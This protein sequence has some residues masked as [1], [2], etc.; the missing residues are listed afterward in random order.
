[1]VDDYRDNDASLLALTRMCIVKSGI[2]LHSAISFCE[3][4]HYLDENAYDIVLMRADMKTGGSTHYENK[5]RD[6]TIPY[7]Q[8]V[9]RLVEKTDAHFIPYTT[10]AEFSDKSMEIWNSMRKNDVRFHGKEMAE[11]LGHPGQERPAAVARALVKIL[12]DRK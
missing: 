4:R 11:Y 12:S 10:A 6:S 8:D 9:I 5:I 1:M 3:A 2:K 7:L